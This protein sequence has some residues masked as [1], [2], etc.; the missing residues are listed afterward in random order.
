[1]S[2]P[3]SPLYPLL[4][5]IKHASKS[6]MPLI[7]IG[8]AV[9]LPDIC[10]SLISEDGRS[11]GALYVA[12]CDENL[13]EKFNFITGKDM[14]SMR[15]GVLHNGRFGDLKHNVARVIF[16]LPDSGT[17]IN[18]Q[19]NDAYFYSVQEFCSG[20]TDAA[21]QWMEANKDNKNIVENLPRLMQYRH[22]G[23]PPYVGGATV[24][25]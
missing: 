15:C 21:F 16:A 9:A 23:L 13:G 11:T 10:V 2:E 5:E 24:L 17:M 12:W 22:D 3:C 25:A 6:G 1:M 4:N 14:W 8:M 20:V 7:A 18:C 19:I